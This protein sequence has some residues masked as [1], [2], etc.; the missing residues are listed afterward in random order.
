[1]EGSRDRRGRNTASSEEV[2]QSMTF[3]DKGNQISG[4]FKCGFIG[5]C[6]FTGVKVRSAPKDNHVDPEAQWVNH[7]PAAYEYARQARW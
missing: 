4:T 3:S 6:H 2:V 1:M 5:E 7:G